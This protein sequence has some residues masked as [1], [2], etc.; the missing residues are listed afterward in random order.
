MPS[1]TGA[2]AAP[3]EPE[4]DFVDIFEA[5]FDELR[6]R[7]TQQIER[8][9]TLAEIDAAPIADQSAEVIHEALNAHDAQRAGDFAGLAERSFDLAAKALLTGLMAQRR[10]A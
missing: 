4:T 5:L 9:L 1:T 10:S 8:G 6:L 7:F 3:N 2:V